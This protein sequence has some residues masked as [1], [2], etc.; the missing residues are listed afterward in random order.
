MTIEISLS[1][2]YTYI[3]MIIEKVAEITSSLIV[4]YFVLDIQPVLVLLERWASIEKQK[5][6]VQWLKKFQKVAMIIALVNGVVLVAS[7]GY[8]YIVDGQ[9]APVRPEAFA[10]H[11]I[12]F[13]I[14]IG[15]II[16]A[17]QS[18]RRL[19]K[20]RKRFVKK[21][22]ALKKWAILTIVAYILI[23]I[24][25]YY[26]V[27]VYADKIVKN[28]GLS[29]IHGYVVFRKINIYLAYKFINSTIAFSFLWLS[30]KLAASERT[31]PLSI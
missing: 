6:R 1:N 16:L 22:K 4:C 13:V 17:L 26:Q 28:L 5:K 12:K 20:I 9:N 19:K 27:S 25:A 2:D 10:A 11:T 8:S 7:R 30:I 15:V 24:F 23:A 14:D 18:L 3:Y 29:N 31:K 21:K